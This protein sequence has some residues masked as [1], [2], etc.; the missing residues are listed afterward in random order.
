MASTGGTV[1]SI[2]LPGVFVKMMDSGNR[3]EAAQLRLD[4]RPRIPPGQHAVEALPNMGGRRKRDR[5][6]F[7]N[8]R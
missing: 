5:I 6:A 8:H 4:G 1:V 3:A 7:E 2:G